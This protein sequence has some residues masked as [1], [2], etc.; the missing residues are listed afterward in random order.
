M[1]SK[2]I[3]LRRLSTYTDNILREIQLYVQQAI[4]GIIDGT[5]ESMTNDKATYVRDYG[6]YKHQSLTSVDFSA[7]TKIG[8][9]SFYQCPSLSS[10]DIPLAE[11]IGAFAFRECNSLVNIS[12]SN[13]IAV[14]DGVFDE[15]V[16]LSSVSFENLQEI[17]SLMFRKCEALTT[18]NF[19][20]VANINTQAFYSS[21]ITSLTL[22]S[23]TVCTLESPDAFYFTPIEEG[24]GY[25][26]VPSDLVDSYKAAD[27]WSV[28]A[29][30]IRAIE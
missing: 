14:G 24:V 15:C 6:F 11:E 30:Q 29:N 20:A 5:I 21:G 18:V 17:T 26:Y 2:Y 4:Y 10:V 25:I 23:N 16:N 19:P 7:A 13:V 12:F 27:G 22:S 9:Y 28:Y 8:D 1:E 3:S